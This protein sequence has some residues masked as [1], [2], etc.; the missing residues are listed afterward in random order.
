MTPGT[1]PRAFW[2]RY[3]SFVERRRGIL[4]LGALALTV[5]GGLGA[6]RLQLKA[7]FGELLPKDAPSLR[8]LDRIQ[9]RM[10]GLN[11]LVVAV[12]GGDWKKRQQFVERAAKALRE[13]IPPARLSHIDYKIIETRKHFEK[14]RYLYVDTEDLRELRRR[15]KTKIEDVRRRKL[16]IDL[17][18]TPPY[19][20]KI[21]DIQKKYE[22]KAAE[23]DNFP[24]DYFITPDRTLQVLLLRVSSAAVAEAGSEELIAEVKRVMDG[25]EAPR[26]GYQ[27]RI[28][29]DPVL[30]IEEREA[31]VEDLIVVLVACILLVILSIVAYY[32]TVRSLFIIAAPVAVGVSLSFGL[33]WLVVGSLNSNTAFLGSIIVGNGINFAIILQARF[34]EDLRR[35]HSAHE[36]LRTALRQTWLATATAALAASIAYG[37]LMVT[38]FRGFSQFGFIG[39]VGMILCWLATFTVAPALL[40]ALEARWPTRAQRHKPWAPRAPGRINAFFQAHHRTIAVAGMV[41]TAVTAV[42]AAWFYRDPFEYDFTKLRSRRASD[43]GA[44]ELGRRVV[45]IFKEARFMGGSP[46]VVLVDRP[47]QVDLLVEALRRKKA[48][49]MRVDTTRSLSDVLPKD[50]ADKIPILNEIR[51][52]LDKKA[53]GW[54]TPEQRKEAEKYRPPPDLKVLSVEDL[55]EMVV[56]PFTEKNGRKGLIVFVY[57]TVDMFQGKQLIE[58]A[59]DF[60]EIPLAN[61]EVIR[62]GGGE[63]ILAD[64]LES[65]LADG[66]IATLASFVGVLLLVTFAFRRFRDRI[67]VLAT[68]VGGVLWMCGVAALLGIRVNMLNFVALPITFGIGVDYP[69]NVYRRY[70]Q[71]GPGAMGQALWSTGGAVTLCSLTTIIGYSSLLFAD[72]RALN[73]FGMLAVVGEATTLAA[74]LLWMP[75]LVHL[76]DRRH[77]EELARREAVARASPQG[78]AGEGESP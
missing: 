7:D 10:G 52:L 37:S 78:E 6:S 65:V 46:S 24:D 27:V 13:K 35:G 2:D 17:E 42:G 25:L 12:E 22:K 51:D 28:G 40:M 47:D 8:E 21:D 48:E 73:S 44:S 38:A 61:G 9:E 77:Y 50:Q 4:L 64:I 68:L 57:R 67:V 43:T 59:K 55:P 60:R 18:N 20:F 53:I 36:A 16:V 1:P 31:V 19:E 5:L 15:L 66:P 26:H 58:F 41:L 62:T 56:R 71:E 34:I 3:A 32:R 70:E 30:A 29:G 39:G 69:V 23:Y 54:M 49:G 74:A 45:Q 63:L 14:Y 76:V 33:A 72:T 75:A 11:T